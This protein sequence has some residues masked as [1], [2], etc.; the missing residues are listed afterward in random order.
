M[1]PT[2]IMQT[3]CP[4]CTRN[5]PQ[6]TGAVIYPHRPD[7]AVKLFYRC[8]P[9]DAYVGCHPDGKPLGRLAD[10]ELRRAK[11]EAHGAFDPLWEPRSAQTLA[12]PDEPRPQKKL[13]RVMRSRAYA[14]LSAQLGLSIDDTHIGMLDVDGCRRVVAVIRAARVDAGQIREWA[15]AQRGVTA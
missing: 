12:Y 9:C 7:L 13:Q 10:A 2:G 4:Y 15:K 11:I 8:L 14:W 3:I 6:V 1:T 5:A